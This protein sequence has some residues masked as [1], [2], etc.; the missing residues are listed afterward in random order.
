MLTSVEN[1][2][3]GTVKT[4]KQIHTNSKRSSDSFEPSRS[5]KERSKK[6]PMVCTGV[7]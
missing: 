6:D 1:S 4:Y 3:F 7:P 5:F 2:V